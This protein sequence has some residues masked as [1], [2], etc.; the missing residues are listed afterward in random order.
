VIKAKNVYKTFYAPHEIPALVDVTAN[1]KAG[2]VVV[3]IGPSG[4]GKSTFLRC[5]NRLEHATSGHIFIDGTDILAQK[6]DINK[7]RAEV[8][9]VFQSFNLFPHK[10]VLENV[11]LAQKVV[12]KRSGDESLK[13]AM[14]LLEKV[15]IVDKKDVYPDQLSGGQQQRVAI[16]RALAMDPKIML[17][18]EPTSALDPEMIGEV[19]DV[20]KTLAKEGMTM[21]VVT[22]EMGFA[23][24]VADRVIFMDAGA[25][26]EE[27]TPEHFFVSPT[28]D[29]TKLFLS[30]IL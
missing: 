20:M 14:A 25:I 22:H 4:S 27:G 24:E 23:R 17:F 15:G 8:G 16:A 30:Q 5:L 6:T 10:T 1:I 29:R 13:K 18:D 12:R 11:T 2:E 7:I 26:V 19:L 9:M 3:V 28:H 21:V